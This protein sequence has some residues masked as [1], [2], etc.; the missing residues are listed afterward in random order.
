MEDITQDA[1]SLFQVSITMTCTMSTKC[2]LS[3]AKECD[4]P[5]YVSC[6]VLVQHAR[7]ARH[8]V[9]VMLQNKLVIIS[10]KYVQTLHCWAFK[11]H[12]LISLTEET[13]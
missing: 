2:D 4:N 10:D 12:D 1:V 8:D 5:I 11:E 7:A 13:V 9:P 3:V 6:A